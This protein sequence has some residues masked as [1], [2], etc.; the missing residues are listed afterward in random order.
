MSPLPPQIEAV[1]HDRCALANFPAHRLATDDDGGQRAIL[2]KGARIEDQGHH[3]AMQPVDAAQL[4]AGKPA[5]F[6]FPL[7]RPRQG[8][9]LAGKA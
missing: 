6:A 4:V 3:L 2:G 8:F 1:D 7:L 9:G 5:V